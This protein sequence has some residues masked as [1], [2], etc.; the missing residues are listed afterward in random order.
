MKKITSLSEINKDC[1]LTENEAIEAR[2]FLVETEMK[3]K[4]GEL[5]KIMF[6]P[7]QIKNKNCENL[8]GAVQIPVGVAGPLL[9]NNKKYFLP[10]AT[11]EGALVASVN[12]GCKA[13]ADS[14]GALACGENVG[15]TR[16]PVFQTKGVKDGLEFLNWLKGNRTLIQKIAETTSSHLRFL[17]VEGQVVGKNV[18]LRLSFDTDNA[19]GMN[20]VTVACEKICRE[21]ELLRKD[22]K[23]LALSGNYCIDKKP[24][25]LNFIQ[26]RGKKIWAEVHLKKNTIEQV[27][28]TSAEKFVEV[29][30]KKNLLGSALTGS[31]GYNAHFGNVVAAVF[32]ATGQDAAHITEGSLGVSFAEK[33]GKEDLYFSVYLPDVVCGTVG[34]G[35]SL[36]AQQEALAILSCQS[37]LELAMVL[38]GA[39]L[40]GE[41][42]LIASLAEN[43]LAAAHEKLGRGKKQ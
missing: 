42:S 1:S 9:L 39:V 11:L 5:K 37:S 19:M 33:E 17:G 35:T 26:G 20:M 43:S 34:G 29:A 25:A 15:M 31:W 40:A 7:T 2:Q 30:I 12:R 23:L 21:L 24:A 6:D 27:F 14:G 13:I 10:L 41:L 4:F 38:G 32:L 36:P 18:Y 8:L 3:I 16:G 22:I 28:H